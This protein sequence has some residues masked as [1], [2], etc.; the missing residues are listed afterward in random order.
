MSEEDHKPEL[1]DLIGAIYDAAI[2]PKLWW[3][4]LDQ[5]R[6]HFGFHMAALGVTALPSGDA[7]IQVSA[8][9]PPEYAVAIPKYGE[10][11]VAIW[12]GPQRASQLPLEEPLLLT[13]ATRREDWIDN[14]FYLEWARPQGIVDQVAMF[15]ARDATMLGSLGLSIHESSAGP[16]EDDMQNLRLLAPHIRRS[17]TISRLLERS[18]E[19]A[20]TFAAALEASRT[21]I[22]IV[23]GD[24]RIR[25]ANASAETMLRAGD[26]VRRVAG[27]LALRNE[28]QPGQLKAAITLADRDEGRL[29][30]RG[31]GLPARL[32]DGTVLA[33]H[34]MPLKRRSRESG[35]GPNAS[36]AI[37]ISETGRAPGLPAEA[38]GLLY[39][40]TP[41][42][43]RAFE[44]IVEGHSTAQVAHMLAVAPS[45]LRTHLLAV[46]AKTGRRN[47]ADLVRLSREIALPG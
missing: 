19:I 12:G 6:T 30:R 14:P 40:L 10:A 32:A 3:P 21:A 41:A 47:R 42:E 28:L 43:S 31:I 2:D 15:L 4:V 23:E 36:A 39:G 8:N 37:F 45:T 44:L 33:L 20:D 1:F 22:V 34:V 5:I 17:V 29:G 27:Q 11:A 18:A 9:I 16:T 38:L 25:F 46:F 35:F 24:L 26:P 13:Q 7:V